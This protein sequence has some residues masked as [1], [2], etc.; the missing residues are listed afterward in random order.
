[1]P[2]QGRLATVALR[3]DWVRE[4]TVIHLRGRERGAAHARRGFRAFA[5]YNA[6]LLVGMGEPE[7]KLPASTGRAKP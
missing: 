7:L 5:G 2:G 3:C 6:R 1:M 4:C